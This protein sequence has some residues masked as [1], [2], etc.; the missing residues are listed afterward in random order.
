MSLN[1]E[2]IA[3]TTLLCSLKILVNVGGAG[4]EE[5]ERKG[6]GWYGKRGRDIPGRGKSR[7]EGPEVG[8][9]LVLLKKRK[10]ATVAEQ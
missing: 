5:E 2:S 8:K 4:R 10:E 1:P 7:S 6:R 3:L 9:D